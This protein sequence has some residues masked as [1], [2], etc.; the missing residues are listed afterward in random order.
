MTCESETNSH[1]AIEQVQTVDAMEAGMEAY[2]TE[3]DVYTDLP[4]AV[5]TKFGAMNLEQFWEFAAR[6][7]RSLDEH[8]ASFI[9]NQMTE[10]VCTCNLACELV[11]CTTTG[12]IYAVEEKYIQKFSSLIPLESVFETSKFEFSAIDLVNL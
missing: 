8:T 6:S 12:G 3:L 5:I 2:N 4:Q 9:R 10:E 1:G 7:Q 11:W